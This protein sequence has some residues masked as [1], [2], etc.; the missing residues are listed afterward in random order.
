MAPIGRV[1]VI[2]RQRGEAAR[3]GASGRFRELVA[4]PPLT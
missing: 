2:M 1:E 4:L 3:L